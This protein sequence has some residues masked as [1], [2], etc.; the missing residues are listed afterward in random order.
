MSISC[1]ATERAELTAV[2]HGGRASV[3]DIKEHTTP[4]A[5]ALLQLSYVRK[6]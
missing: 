4:Q 2:G 1:C 6:T 5:S 3:L